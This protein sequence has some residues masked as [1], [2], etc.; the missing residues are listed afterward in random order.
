M[1][2]LT[3]GTI[4]A[5]TYEI[6]E[7]RGSGGGGIVFKGRHL[8]LNTDIVVKKIKDEVLMAIDTRKEAD[9]L[10]NL[11]H[12][13]LPK[14]YDFIEREDGVYTVMDFIQGGD[15]ARSGAPPRSAA[16]CATSW[17]A[18]PWAA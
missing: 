1:T 13:Y 17:C 9:T 4:L 18:P 10:K 5:D 14:V 2:T 8:R 15:M 12:Q 16:R 7:E 11:K 3:K 6:T